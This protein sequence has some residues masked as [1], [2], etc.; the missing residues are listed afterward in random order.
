M[1]FQTYFTISPTALASP[2]WRVRLVLF[3]GVRE[4]CGVAA[5]LADPAQDGIQV[6]I[7][8]DR[9]GCR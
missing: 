5:R 4:V 7:C 3:G 8:A 9:S 1:L 2:I 6:I